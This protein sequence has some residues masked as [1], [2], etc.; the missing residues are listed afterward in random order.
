MC[1]C[2]TLSTWKYI[3]GFNF[4]PPAFAVQHT[5]TLT[6]LFPVDLRGTSFV[7]VM[8]TITFPTMSDEMAASPIAITQSGEELFHGQFS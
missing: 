6:F 2:I 8:S 7:P 1:C 5:V 3:K 4:I